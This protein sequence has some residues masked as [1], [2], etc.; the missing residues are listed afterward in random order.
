MRGSTGGRELKVVHN[1]AK[2]QN[3]F[4]SCARELVVGYSEDLVDA[5]R[6]CEEEVVYYVSPK[7][8]KAKA[9]NLQA[10]SSNVLH[11]S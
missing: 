4:D 3:V 1:F 9:I 10:G 6:H 2:S 11:G 5:G 8:F 7:C